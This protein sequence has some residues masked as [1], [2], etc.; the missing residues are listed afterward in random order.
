MSM[1]KSNTVILTAFLLFATLNNGIAQKLELPKAQYQVQGNGIPAKPGTICYTQPD[2]SKINISLK[3]D[4]VAHWAISDDG[5]T[6]ISNSNKFYEYAKLDANANLVSTGIVA[7]NAANRKS[8]EIAVLNNISKGIN[9]SDKQIKQKLSNYKSTSNKEVQ[10]SSFQS[11]GTQNFIVLMV[12]YSDLSFSN[13]VTNVDQL[14]NQPNYNGTG[15]FKDFYFKNSNEK[16]TVN[17]TVSG[18]YTASR[19]HDYYGQNDGNGND[20][21]VAELVSEAIQAADATVDF[22]QFDNNNDGVVDAVY[23]IYAGSGEA[24]SGNPT[25]I[26]P[27]NNP[28]ITP[29]TVDGVIINAYTCSNELVG[30]SLVG[31]GTICHE[32]GHALGLPDYY[33]TD[34]AGSGGQAEGNGSWDVMASGNSNNNEASP[35]NHNPM[36]KKMLGWQYPQIIDANGPYV[37]APATQ[38]T[39]SFLVNSVVASEGFFLENRQLE[40]FDIGLQ[41]HGMLIFHCDYAYFDQTHLTNNNINANPAHQGFDIEEADGE[42]TIEAG[43]TYPGTTSNTSFT[44]LTTPSS[45]L[46]AGV[47]FE[48]PIVNIVENSTSKNIEF[49]I[50]GFTGIHDIL[51]NNE[52]TVSPTLA[53]DFI[54]VK[55]NENIQHV[56]LINLQGQVVFQT[57]VSNL[58]TRLNVSNIAAGSYFVKTKTTNHTSISK[59]I[60]GK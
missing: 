21:N 4:G 15:S 37:L 7:K 42:I 43:D 25:D 31:I 50:S 45:L 27:H 56:S 18:I 24:S 38:D 23:I 30:T 29:I 57:S 36:S 60:I 52:I 53:Y 8:A 58:Q 13:T 41:G 26:W 14:M 39:I 35:A 34:Y 49:N 17:T 5:Y 22:S 59:I 3:G 44:D 46:W 32:F 28:S 51:T 10:T 12:Q 48:L 47:G 20:M 33:D 16:L 19:T 40:G 9:Y 2:G 6:L 54:D 11:T 1:K 55:S